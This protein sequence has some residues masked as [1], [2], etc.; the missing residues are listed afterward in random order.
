M[1]LPVST[2]VQPL[3]PSLPWRLTAAAISGT[4][5]LAARFFLHGLNRVEVNGL[6]NLLD[7]L[8]RR[9]S[10]GRERGLLTVCN[11][12]SV[13]DD[14]IM[15]G[16]LPVR[17]MFDP[18]NLRWGLGAHDICFKNRHVLSCYVYNMHVLTNP[19][20]FT[21]NF[22]TLGQVLPTHRLWHSTAGG[23]YQ[24][25][26]TQA[27]KLLSRHHPS[28]PGLA[29]YSTNGRDSFTSPAAYAANCN[30]W[31][32][33]FPE[34]CCHQSEGSTLRYFKWGVARL[35]LESDPAPEFIP[36]FIDGTQDI[37]S[38]KR[39]W[40][41]FLPRIGKRFRVVIGQ[42]SLVEHR[43]DR[44][45]AAWQKLMETGDP[46]L[47]KNGPEAVQLRVEVAKSVRDEVE[48]LRVSLG[49]PPEED[50]AAALAETWD[51]EPN[52]RKFQ[53]PVDGSLVN[54]H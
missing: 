38:E 48:K 53:S 16:I 2:S 22:F 50:E 13:L 30:A 12:L 32:H 52:K 5:G 35:I 31:V 29:T 51:K 54:R 21:S 45:R 10:Q 42:P 11:H 26:M 3:R 28:S 36:M 14:P 43:F 39:T 44:H 20:S 15:W 46:E 6:E 41:R 49:F 4:V 9:K 1:T 37:M 19:G 24:P 18:E 25:T 7:V 17:Y 40:P 34:A 33:V 8:D 47:V 23:I 27:L